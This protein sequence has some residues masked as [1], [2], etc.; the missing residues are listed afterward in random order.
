MI[1]IKL[2]QGAKPAHGG[3]YRKK[4]LLLKL[5]KSAMYLWAKMSYRLRHTQLFS[6]P[7]ELCQFIQQL[8]ELSDGEA[9]WL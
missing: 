1:E 6:T 8:R 3:V 7:V 5:Q 4:S 2:S 9:Y